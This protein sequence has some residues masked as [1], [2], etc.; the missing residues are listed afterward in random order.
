MLIFTFGLLVYLFLSI[1]T[2]LLITY[3]YPKF[4][5]KRVLMNNILFSPFLASILYLKGTS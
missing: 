1:W 4:D 5:F 3:C 2:A